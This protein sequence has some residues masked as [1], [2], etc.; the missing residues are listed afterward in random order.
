MRLA[1]NLL[2]K[3]YINFPFRGYDGPDDWIMYR[4]GILI[5]LEFEKNCE[6]KRG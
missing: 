5:T 2:A 3:T 1:I 4:L 6:K